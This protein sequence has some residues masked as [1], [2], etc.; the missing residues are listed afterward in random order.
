MKLAIGLENTKESWELFESFFEKVKCPAYTLDV[1]VVQ[2]MEEQVKEILAL[3][4]KVEA[5]L[6][7]EGVNGKVI[8]EAGDPVGRI[9]KLIKDRDINVFVCHYEHSILGTSFFEGIM[10]ETDIPVLTL[11]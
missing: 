10:R 9:V 4:K 11:R 7:K 2:E 1:F 5:K 3:K 6:E 8:V